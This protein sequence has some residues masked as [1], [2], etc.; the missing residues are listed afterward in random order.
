MYVST[1]IDGRYPLQPHRLVVTESLSDSLGLILWRRAFNSRLRAKVKVVL[2]ERAEAIR[3]G[4]S[5][6]IGEGIAIDA[7]HERIGVVD[8]RSVRVRIRRT[9]HR[10]GSVIG[11]RAAKLLLV[12]VDVGY[13][14]TRDPGDIAADIQRLR[15]SGIVLSCRRSLGINRGSVVFVSGLR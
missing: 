8:R 6:G 5:R 1:R 7:I 12:V 13:V 2:H 9:Q 11:K 10:A 3:V 4:H 14:P 15:I